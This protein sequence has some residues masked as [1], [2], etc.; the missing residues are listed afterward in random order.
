MKSFPF[1][2]VPL[3]K[4][5]LL[6]TLLVVMHWAGQNLEKLEKSRSP[7]G[8]KLEKSRR[9]STQ[10]LVMFLAGQVRRLYLL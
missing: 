5:R 2:P 7:A 6:S 1:C 10:L 9:S 8:H 4:S 3:E